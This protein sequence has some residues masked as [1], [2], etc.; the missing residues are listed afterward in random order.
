MQ[1]QSS[2]SHF[3]M[4]AHP[5]KTNAPET[6][7]SE[8]RDWRRRFYKCVEFDFGVLKQILVGYC[9]RL[10]S[11]SGMVQFCISLP[12][13]LKTLCALCVQGDVKVA[14]G[15]RQEWWQVSI[16]IGC[17]LYAWLRCC[18]ME[19]PGLILRYFMT[20]SSGYMPCSASPAAK[21][22]PRGSQHRS[23]SS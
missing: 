22:G 23:A 19:R 11:H 16:C 12:W 3:P 8:V 5:W 9:S 7:V 4:I 10:H 14:D 21:A 18:G 20:Y 1:G 6:Q 15:R 17:W 13:L 2:T